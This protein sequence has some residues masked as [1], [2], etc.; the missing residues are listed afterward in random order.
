MLTIVAIVAGANVASRA[1]SQA[2]MTRHTRDV[3][4]N[5]Q[6]PSLG[7]LSSPK[8]LDI[9]LHLPLRD[10]QGL[11]NFL[12][13][14][15]DPSSPSYRQFLTVAQFTERF[16]P[17]AADYETVK[18]FARAN[19]LK[20]LS[21]SPNR[22]ILQVRGSVA[23]IEKA[24]HV[25]MNLYHDPIENRAFFA[26]DREPSADM[27]VRLWHVGGLDNYSV[28]KAMYVRRDPNTS[29]D[30]KSNATTGSGPSAS[31]LGS[32][33]RAAYYGGTALTGAGQTLGLFELIGTDLA[34]L[35]T[36]YTNVGQTN[37]VPVTLKSVDSQSTACTDNSA[38]GFCDDTEQTLDMTQ[39]LGMAPGLTGLTMFIGTGGKS[40]QSVD[41]EGILNSMAST[42]P[43]VSTLSCSWAWKPTDNTTDDPIFQEFA[44][45]G[46]N[47]FTA[48]GDSGKWTSGG[49]VWPADDTNVVSVGGTSLKTSSAA[50]PWSSETAWVDGG[51]G[52][53]TNKFAIPSWQVA[54]AAS[55]AKCSQT[56][57]NG[58]D[59]SANADFSFYVCADQ[60][61]CTANNYGGTS[62]AAPM[63]AAYI[64]LAN[65]QAVSNGQP[66]LGFI[67]PALYAILAGSSYGTDFHDILTGG[68]SY[69]ATVGYDLASGIGSP[70]GV[71]LI[72]ALVPVAPPSFS[73]S[74]SPSS[75]TVAQ[76][77][78]GTS[79]ITSTLANGFNA[80]V[81][82]KAS[83][84]GVTFSPNPIPAPGSGTSKA[85]IKIAKT[86][87]VGKHTL[88]ITGT[89]GGDT[90]T[91]TIT[92]TVTK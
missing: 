11:D 2:L 85:T 48:S 23:N 49:F 44:A 81:T 8:T 52:I 74:A 17:T 84:G 14:V 16:G 26:P 19:G 24:L 43:L 58:P 20:I 45:Q 63:W 67:N 72:N 10:Q 4:V 18:D 31:F 12:K 69:G 78:S 6:A 76:G 3:V 54:A 25:T 36:Y 60:T 57:R 89:G 37:N 27:P 88:T 53:S 65:Q 66:T 59:V 38:G 70:N 39:A 35:T 28:P 5:G 47:F 9:V 7:H 56:Y 34:D 29:S 64:A 68:N 75:I 86:V 50:G 77:S 51:G 33:M 90:A 21:T 79:T 82:L 62:F 83:I 15:S 30:A 1:E 32:D 40:G 91:T 71:A 42:V 92:V 80:A 55:C 73:L 13:E 61:K 87:T 41:D 46:Q 22:A